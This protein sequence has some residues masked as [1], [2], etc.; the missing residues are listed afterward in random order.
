MSLPTGAS[1]ASS[2][3]PLLSSL[4][5]SSDAEH[6]IPCDSTPR[7]LAFLILKSPGSSA[8]IMANGILMPARALGAPQTTWK[9]SAPLLTWHTR[10]LSASGCC[11][12]LRISPTTMPLKAPA[13]GCTASTSRPTMDR[14]ATKS[15]RDTSGFT[16]LR[17]HCSLNFML[18][19]LLK[20]I[21]SRGAAASEIAP[22]TAG[23]YRRTGASH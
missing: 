9:V 4:I 19:V 8:P 10:S 2:I 17:S 18:S 6:S 22:G 16:Q 20:R 21:R 13:T 12:A 14:R 1:A 15:S 23:R 3:R 11:S 5:C 7:S